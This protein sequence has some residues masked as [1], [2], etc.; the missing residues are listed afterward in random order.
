M[1]DG[2]AVPAK[3]LTGSCCRRCRASGRGSSDLVL[4]LLM[5]QLRK[6]LRVRCSL[7]L[8]SQ[9][10]SLRCGSLLLRRV[11]GHLRRKAL[12]PEPR[13]LRSAREV[14][15]LRHEGPGRRPWHPSI[16]RERLP[17]IGQRSSGAAWE[18]QRILA[19]EP[20]G[21]RLR[22]RLLLLRLRLLR[23]LLLPTA[24]PGASTTRACKWVC[25]SREA[26]SRDSSLLS[27][28]R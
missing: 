22:L 1:L 8:C 14:G 21:L 15:V 2:L 11:L 5:F 20:L 4:V 17:D 23:L 16:Q 27:L 26:S 19:L 10:G 3:M 18:R 6:L 9:S 24:E 25:G 28:E 13:Q 7:R 12:I